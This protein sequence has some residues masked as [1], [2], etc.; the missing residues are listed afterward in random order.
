VAASNLVSTK[1][2]MPG[3]IIVFL[4][5]QLRMPLCVFHVLFL[6]NMNLL[7]VLKDSD[8][9]DQTV[10]MVES[11]KFESLQK[12][13]PHF[14]LSLPLNTQDDEL[15]RYLIFNEHFVLF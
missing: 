10:Y 11:T 5:C 13:S 9:E 8:R 12:I 3:N 4:D 15:F 6:L 2:T 7:R 14:S 1:L